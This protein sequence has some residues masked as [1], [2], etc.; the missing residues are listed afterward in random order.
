[1]CP[2][3]KCFVCM[4][5]FHLQKLYEIGNIFLIIILPMKKPRH[6]KFR[7]LPEVRHLSQFSRSVMFATPWTAAHQPSLCIT[8]SG[9]CSNS[10]PSSQWRHPNISSSVS[11]CLQS[12]PA[13]G[14]FQMSQFFESGSQSIRVSASASVLAMNIQD[15]SPLGL[16]GLISL[17]SKGLSRVFSNTTVPKHQFFGAQLYLWSNSHSH[18]WLLE[19][20]QLWI[21]ETLLDL[22]CQTPSKW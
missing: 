8:N 9:G 17:R 15:W 3:F 4:N 14:S 2:A 12:F 7:N 20:P 16:T 22:C 1:M 19:K 11:S 18:T 5:S 13:S 10:C 6:K 21:D